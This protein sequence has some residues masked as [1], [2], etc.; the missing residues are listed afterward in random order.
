MHIISRKPLRDFSERHPPA[1]TP[2]D[3]WF[4]EVSRAK[5]ASFADVKKAFGSADV[6]AGNRVIFN[7][8]GNKYRLVVKIAYKVGIVFVRFIGTHVEYDKIDA[9]TI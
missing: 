8:G 5:W 4:A 7:I 9:N 1:K 6:V 3:A 2:L